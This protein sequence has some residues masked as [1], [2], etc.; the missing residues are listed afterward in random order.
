MLADVGEAQP[1]QPIA[2]P[3]RVRLVDREFEKVDALVARRRRRYEQCLGGRRGPGG[4]AQAL[5]GQ[6]LQVQQGAQAI[7][8]HTTRRRGAEAIVEHF[9]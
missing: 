2:Q 5:A 7:G 3:R 1:L 8:S 6:F 4:S 9:Q